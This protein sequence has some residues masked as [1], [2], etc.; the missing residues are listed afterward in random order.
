MAICS[1]MIRT[2]SV[3]LKV[4]VSNAILVL[5]DKIQVAAKQAEHGKLSALGVMA[6]LLRCS[7]MLPLRFEDCLPLREGVVRRGA[8]KNPAICFAETCATFVGVHTAPDITN[9]M[10][11][12]SG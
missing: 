2:Q 4:L 1:D 5:F 3:A 6:L 12:R 9:R 10:S 11:S 8:P 7:P